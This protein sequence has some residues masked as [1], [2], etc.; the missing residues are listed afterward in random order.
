MNPNEADKGPT[1]FNRRDFIRSTSSFGAMMLLMGGVPLHAE[2]KPAAPAEGGATAYSTVSAPVA[3]GVIGCG[4]WG[5]E[6]IATLGKL[7]NAP[8]VAVCDTYEAF[9]RRGK[10]A[11]P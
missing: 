4:P 8:V 2:D 10:E 3:C 7:P 5:R 6:V 9:L 11:A 1:E